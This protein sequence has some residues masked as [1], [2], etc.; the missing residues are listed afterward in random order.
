MTNHPF[1]DRFRELSWRRRLTPVEEAELGV[2]LR[3]HPEAQAQWEAE[4]GLTEALRRLPDAPVSSN[5]TARVLAAAEREE[6]GAAARARGQARLW[7]GW[8]GWLTRKLAF[9]AVVVTA[10]VLSYHHFQ[11]SHRAELVRSVK[12]LSEVAS[13]P[14][15]L[16]DFDAIQRLVSAPQADEEL[17]KLLQ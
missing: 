6:N 2:W 13:M 8:A 5:F 3:S 11:A 16:Q 15:I 9:G 17:L 10:G 4:A 7:P 14:D 1:Y 12:T